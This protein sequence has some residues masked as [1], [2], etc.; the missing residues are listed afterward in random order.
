[1]PADA[2]LSS[3]DLNLTDPAFFANGDPHALWRRMREEDPVHRTQ[4]S[5]GRFY[6][7]VTRLPDVRTVYTDPVLFSA[8]KSG[9]TLPLTAAF[10]DPARS[11]SIRLAME[12]AM[13]ASNDP[14][15]HNKMRQV[16]H[17]R[18][19]PNAVARMD[20]F[21]RQL[22]T[23]LIGD[24]IQTGECDFVTDIAAKLPSSVIFEIMQLPREDWPMLFEMA[25]M[26]SAPA[27]DDYGAAEALEARTRAVRTI[28]G[29]VQDLAKKRRGGGGG[30]LITILSEAKIDG[31]PFTDNEIGYNGFMFIAA[32]QETT[33]NSLAGG[34]IELIKR[35]AE[36]ARLRND[37]A[38]LTSMPDEFVRWISP[39]THVLRTAT[40]DTELA[41]KAIR[42]GDWVVLWNGSANRDTQAIA[43]ADEFDIG[44]PA[45]PHVGFGAGDH[46]CL[47]AHIARLQLRHIMRVF[48]DHVADIELTGPVRRVASHQFPGFKSMPVRVTRA[49]NAPKLN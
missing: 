49:A 36:M 30:D 29:Y 37:R 34:M 9:A 11:P 12:G 6:W 33:R 31:I 10:A 13:L 45:T 23:T 14:P 17:H 42:E 43:G 7:S 8:Q 28:I 40:A 32:G 39:V 2:S 46:F 24:L 5:Y 26:A 1:M 4:T 41:G 20:D 38:L 22:A 27:D 25:N 47:G 48:L 44:R 21:V 15:R 3:Q 35:P 18:F 19:L 16:L